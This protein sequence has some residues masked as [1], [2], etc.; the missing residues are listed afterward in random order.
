MRNTLRFIF[1]PAPLFT[2]PPPPPRLA[3]RGLVSWRADLAPRPSPAS[4]VGACTVQS[5]LRGNPP[6]LPLPPYRPSSVG[7][8][9]IYFTPCPLVTLPLSPPAVHA[10]FASTVHDNLEA[11]CMTRSLLNCFAFVTLRPPPE[12]LELLCRVTCC[13]P[14]AARCGRLLLQ[15]P[16]RT[17]CRGWPYHMSWGARPWQAPGAPRPAFHC[18]PRGT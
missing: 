2:F 4:F 11:L 12:L 6:P 9:A 1:C 3:A 16:R 15:W 18:I 10:H 13:F 5:K 7:L 17:N 14:K 8:F